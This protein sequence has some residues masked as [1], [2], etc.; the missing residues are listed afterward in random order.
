MGSHGMT[1]QPPPHDNAVWASFA[2]AAIT[3][4]LSHDDG[5]AQPPA[6]IAGWAAQVADNMMTRYEEASEDQENEQ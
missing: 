1:A 2:A 4:Y 5:H 6:V 3:G